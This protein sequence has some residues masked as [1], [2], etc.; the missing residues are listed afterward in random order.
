[1]IVAAC[2]F[3]IPEL[4]G[5]SFAFRAQDD[6]PS[7]TRSHFPPSVCPGGVNLG[8]AKGSV[9]GLMRTPV[10]NSGRPFCRSR[11][12]WN[13]S[14]ELIFDRLDRVGSCCNVC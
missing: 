12:Y 9:S 2:H 10:I 7:F 5:R 6:T 8:A 4:Q 14:P 1:M 11:C 13:S 3:S